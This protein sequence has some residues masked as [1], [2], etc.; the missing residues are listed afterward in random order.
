[1]ARQSLDGRRWAQTLRM[2]KQ[3][4]LPTCATQDLVSTASF[5]NYEFTAE[6]PY[7]QVFAEVSTIRRRDFEMFLSTASYPSVC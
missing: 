1:M 4:S 3:N 7:N 5:F 6:H 2:T